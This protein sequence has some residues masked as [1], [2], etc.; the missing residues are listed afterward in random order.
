M[1]QSPLHSAT[2]L[3]ALPRL[4]VRLGA[5]IGA[6]VLAVAVIAA[7]AYFTQILPGGLRPAS[8]A[9]LARL[10]E[11]AEQPVFAYGT[12]TSGLVRFVVT[13]RVQEARPAVL[14][15]YRRENRDILRGESARVEGVVFD[16][17]PRELRRLDLYERLGERYERIEV[18]LADGTRAWAYRR[19]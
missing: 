16:V 7:G 3:P 18:E 1:P 10:E 19:L 12:L 17:T 15:G 14:T 2:P 8:P 11:E 9:L 5:W 13:F 6:L 4:G